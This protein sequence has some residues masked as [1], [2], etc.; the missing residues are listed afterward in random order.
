MQLPRIQ[1]H[2]HLQTL[3]ETINTQLGDFHVESFAQRV[4]FDDALLVHDVGDLTQL[5][6]C[7][8]AVFDVTFLGM[9][10][11]RFHAIESYT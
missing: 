7:R 2:R 5:H 1:L 4:H 10:R 3:T 8:L 6:E 11:K 9:S